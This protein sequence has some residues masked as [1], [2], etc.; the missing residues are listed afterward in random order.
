M[1]KSELIETLKAGNILTKSEPKVTV[2]L[3][4]DKIPSALGNGDWVE[5]RGRNSFYVK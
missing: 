5:I 4:F 2:N 3:L 1:N